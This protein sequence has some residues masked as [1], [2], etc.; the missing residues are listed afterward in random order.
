M[1]LHLMGGNNDRGVRLDAGWLLTNIL[2]VDLELVNRI[3]THNYKMILELFTSMYLEEADADFNE[4]V[5][6][7]TCILFPSP[8]SLN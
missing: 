2:T 8:K 7:H 6:K 5:P 4:I 3:A 1:I